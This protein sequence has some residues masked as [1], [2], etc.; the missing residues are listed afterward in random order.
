MQVCVREAALFAKDEGGFVAHHLAQHLPLLL[1][2]LPVQVGL[3]SCEGKSEVRRT[4]RLRRVEWTLGVKLVVVQKLL[5]S[6]LSDE[7]IPIY[8]FP[9]HFH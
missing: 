6:S 1:R 7:S 2:Q 8:W 4:Q 9:T 5:F 3:D